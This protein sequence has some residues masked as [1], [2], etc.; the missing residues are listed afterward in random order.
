MN[1]TQV[2][3][4][5]FMCFKDVALDL[6]N[7]GLVVI[8]GDNQDAH[9]ADSNGAGKSAIYEAIYWCLQGKTRRGLT[10]DDVIHL[11]AGRDCLVEVQIGEFTITRTRKHSQHNNG[12]FVSHGENDLTKGTVRET[13]KVI[14]EILESAEI[15]FGKITYFGQSDIKPFASLTDQELK[16]VFEQAMSFTFLSDYAAKVAQVQKEV[17]EVLSTMNA[18]IEKLEN[19]VRMYDEQIEHVKKALEQE[20]QRKKERLDKQKQVIANL[21]SRISELVDGAKRDTNI[22]DSRKRLREYQAK[23]EALKEEKSRLEDLENGYKRIFQQYTNHKAQCEQAQAEAKKQ[24]E[25]LKKADESVGEKC[26]TCARPFTQDDIE[27]YKEQLSKTVEQAAKDFYAKR[28]RYNETKKEMESLKATLDQVKQ[29]VAGFEDIGAAIERLVAQIQEAEQRQK[30]ADQLREEQRQA[31]EDYKSIEQQKPLQSGQLS[32]YKED[33]SETQGEIKQMMQDKQAIEERLNYLAMLAE[34]FG[35]QGMKSY[36]F[37]RVTPELN[38][39]FNKYL[40][41]LDD[42][43]GEISTQKTLQSGERREKF[44]IDVSHNSGGNSYKGLSA[45]ERNKV[46]LALSLAFN[47]LV[48]EITQHQFDFLFLDEIFEN[49]DE[50][51]SEQVVQLIED[52]ASDISTVFV[53]SHNPAV[54]DIISNKLVVKKQGGSAT[55]EWR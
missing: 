3:A 34:I 43:R 42:M 45:G 32:K 24:L 8:Q 38:K 30:W 46:D 11:Q 9:I 26:A 21:E 44:S 17:Q 49:L 19:K 14:D 10:G 22:E 13:Q 53:I 36:L 39:Y 54:R 23:Q 48:R 16:T 35:S 52:F 25:R 5:N 47:K 15:T 37:D 4:Q 7:K 2:K 50:C 55:L 41:Y 29:E 6:T 18:E 12:L 28:D 40:Q 27:K 20:E 1:N 33:K 51:S 31:K